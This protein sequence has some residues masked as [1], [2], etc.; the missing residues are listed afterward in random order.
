MS[1]CR[2]YA[3]AHMLALVA[4]Q[5][6]RLTNGSIRSLLLSASHLRTQSGPLCEFLRIPWCTHVAHLPLEVQ[7]RRGRWLFTVGSHVEDIEVDCL[8]VAWPLMA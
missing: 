7:G 2:N 8:A 5:L 1:A 4:V 3:T 6:H